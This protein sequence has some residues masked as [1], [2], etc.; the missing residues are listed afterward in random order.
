MKETGR[1][2]VEAYLKKRVLEAGGSTRKFASRINNP[3]QL[4]IWPGGDAFMHFVELKSPGKK[5]RAGQVREHK[6]LR[7]MGCSVFVLDTKPKIDEYV[8]KYK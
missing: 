8:A 7:D 1:Y 3:D 6:R 4:V 5:P 2:G